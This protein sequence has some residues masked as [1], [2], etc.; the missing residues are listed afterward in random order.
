L[1][2]E[3]EKVLRMILTP[4]A[5]QRLRTVRLVKPLLAEQLEDYLVKLFQSGKLNKRISESDMIKL[6][7]KLGEKKSFRIIR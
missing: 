3:K 1:E 2:E 5:L 4:E 6:L 7:E